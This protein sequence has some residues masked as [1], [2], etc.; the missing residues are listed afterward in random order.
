M[1]ISTLVGTQAVV[2]DR[3]Q[4]C[5]NAQAQGIKG[6][7]MTG[8]HI[9]FNLIQTDTA[10]PA[11]DAR[12]VSVYNIFAQADGFKNLG[13]LVGL[14]NRDSHLGCCFDD[15]CKQCIV[16]VLQGCVIIFIQ[17][18][19]VNQF[20]DAF[21]SQVWIDGSGTKAKD[22]RTLMHVTRLAGFQDQGHLGALLS[23]DQV[24]FDRRYSQQ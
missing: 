17:Q 12:E 13:R 14:Q 15:T 6:M 2:A 5:I 3:I 22:G 18:V 23:G 4:R 1:V 8:K 19:L 24:C 10:D 11:G 16:I 20:R 7:V 9:G 21:M